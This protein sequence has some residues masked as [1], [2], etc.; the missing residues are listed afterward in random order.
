MSWLL[1]LG[2]TLALLLAL[3]LA[4]TAT[5]STTD[6][7][8]TGKSLSVIVAAAIVACVHGEACDAEKSTDQ[9]YPDGIFQSNVFHRV[10]SWFH[11][12][13]ETSNRG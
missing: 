4:I 1:A 8:A 9:G 6:R 12:G 13:Y 3:I 7:T 2:R 5:G 11:L 10:T